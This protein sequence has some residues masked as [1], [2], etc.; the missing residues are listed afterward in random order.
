[1]AS[2]Y[3]NLHDSGYWN[4]NKL[5]FCDVLHIIYYVTYDVFYI[6]SHAFCDVFPFTVFHTAK[7]R[8][9]FC[10]SFYFLLYLCE[11][12]FF[13]VRSS[14]LPRSALSSDDSLSELLPHHNGPG[15]LSSVRSSKPSYRNLHRIL[16]SSHR[17]H[18]QGFH[19]PE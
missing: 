1:M 2:L 13:T 17:S 8:D 7:K 6:F 3:L 18:R 9:I 5:Y 10:L 12:H 11:M 14:R 15:I 16:R 19:L 4:T